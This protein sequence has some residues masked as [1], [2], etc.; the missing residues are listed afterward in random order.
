MRLADKHITYI[1][2]KKNTGIIPKSTIV[3]AK[4]NQLHDKTPQIFLLRKRRA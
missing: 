2:Y 3:Y 1:R 4:F